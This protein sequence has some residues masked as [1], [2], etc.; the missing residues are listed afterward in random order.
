MKRRNFIGLTI[1]G[2]AAMSLHTANLSAMNTEMTSIR[3]GG[4][5]F[6]KFSSPENG[7]NFI[8]NWDTRPPIAL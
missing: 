4:P 2:T 8:K 5:V 3:L 1:A 6:E 7:Y